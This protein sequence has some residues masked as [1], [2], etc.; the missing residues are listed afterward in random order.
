ME[1]VL[2]MDLKGGVVVHGKRGDRA[3]YLPLIRG[4]SP[5]AE[6]LGFLQHIRPKSIYI[7]DLDRIGGTGSQ[8]NITVM[9]NSM[10]SHCYADRGCRHPN[11]M[12]HLDHF[13]NVV[14]TETLGEDICRYHGGYL[15]LDMKEGTVIPSGRDPREFLRDSPGWGFDGCILLDI[16]GVGT[17]RGLDHELLSSLRDEY[18]GK[19]LWGGGIAT[20]NDL[21]SLHSAGYDGAIVATAVHN[22]IIPIEMIR[23]GRYC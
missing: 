19:L 16:S 15:S 7:A 20:I 4:L 22:G 2:A 18:E 21:E 11:D 3:N 17:T 9:C 10:V 23:R 13:E 12:L 8:D 5:V 14:G 6:P 1:L